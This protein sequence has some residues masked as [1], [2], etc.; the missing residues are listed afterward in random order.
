MAVSV[1]P[2]APSAAVPAPV[3]TEAPVEDPEEVGPA[4]SVPRPA[5]VVVKTFRAE[6]CFV[7]GLA[8]KQARNDY[9]ATAGGGPSSKRVPRFGGPP[10]RSAVVQLTPFIRNC[11]VAGT[12]KGADDAELD[13]ELTSFAQFAM[14]LATLIHDADAY[15]RDKGHEADAF[16]RG[17]MFHA[18]LLSA[19]TCETSRHKLA[20]P[21]MVTNGFSLLDK[22]VDALRL[23]ISKYELAH[24]VD[25]S[26]MAPSETLSR[27]LVAKSGELVRVFDT[28]AKID[29][30][31][32]KTL[33]DQVAAL[34][35]ELETAPNPD[36]KDPWAR[37]V[38][39][40]SKVF[41]DQATIAYGDGNV[42]RDP[43]L[44]LALIKAHARIREKDF[45]ALQTQ[46]RQQASASKP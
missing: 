13:A 26:Q 39:V 44:V 29:A 32:L 25:T 11:N 14:P 7:G 18:C 2:P 37:T 16:Q 23:A 30:T 38:P 35:Q 6:A 20:S 3:S 45:S 36:G 15:Y 27:S 31:K 42:H 41:L 21:E 12:V 1:Q 33:I 4:V 8:L 24:P 5:P 46:L 43:A 22:K 28:S 17:K 34:H 19:A 40:H 9:R 10:D